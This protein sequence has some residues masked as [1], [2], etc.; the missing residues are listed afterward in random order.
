MSRHPRQRL[1][2]IERACEVILE[3]ARRDPD[4]I[5]ITFDAICMRLL[6]IGEAVK[7]LDDGIRDRAPEVRW[8]GAAAMCDRLAHRY[9]DTAH[10]V[11]MEA[12][13]EDVPALLT[14]VRRLLSESERL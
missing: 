13:R 11:V 14:A 6:E 2:D 1:T 3:Y 12:V 5:G 10:T 7:D 4:L 8:R 9:F